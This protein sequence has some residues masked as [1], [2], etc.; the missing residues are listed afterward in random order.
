MRLEY[1]PLP[2]PQNMEAYPVY[3]NNE[4]QRIARFIGGISE[5]HETGMFLATAGATMAAYHL[6][7]YYHSV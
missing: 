4:L 5:V 2:P 6:T 1:V 3:I 7:R